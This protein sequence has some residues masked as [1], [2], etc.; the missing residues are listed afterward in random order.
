[1]IDLYIPENNLNAEE[2]MALLV[3]PYLRRPALDS[4][5]SRAYVGAEGGPGSDKRAAW[6]TR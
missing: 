3:E 1:M 6:E 2:M 4:F 5:V